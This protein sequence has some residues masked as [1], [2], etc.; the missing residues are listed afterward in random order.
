MQIVMERIMECLHAFPLSVNAITQIK[1]LYASSRVDLIG[2][3]LFPAAGNRPCGRLE[4]R[5]LF[6][7]AVDNQAN[8]K[9]GT[10]KM[11]YRFHAKT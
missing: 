2:T 6:S 9:N 8:I 7:Y 3:W 1:R 4:S 11:R 5:G 10:V